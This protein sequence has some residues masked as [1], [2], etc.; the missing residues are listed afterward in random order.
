ME[1]ARVAAAAR[2]SQEGS[3]DYH[4]AA[5]EEEEECDSAAQQMRGA[6][7]G[8]VSACVHVPGYVA[9]YVCGRYACIVAKCIRMHSVCMYR[10]GLGPQEGPNIIQA[11]LGCGTQSLESKWH[12]YRTSSYTHAT[13]PCTTSM[14]V[15]V[16]TQ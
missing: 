13:R 1:R 5:G 14:V 3:L 10:L 9:L 12:G 11:V 15:P 6:A 7:H 8:L 16:T 2:V 4:V